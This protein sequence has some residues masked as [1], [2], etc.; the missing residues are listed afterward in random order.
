[1]CVHFFLQPL[2]KTNKRTSAIENEEFIDH[3]I[4]EKVF[5]V[6]VMMF[7]I[8]P[9]ISDFSVNLPSYVLHTAVDHIFI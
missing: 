5:V 6:L 4:K 3:L 7:S 1:M 9:T 2:E 8:F